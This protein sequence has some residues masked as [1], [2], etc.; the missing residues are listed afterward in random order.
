MPLDSV[1]EKIRVAYVEEEG[2]R[3][4]QEFVNTAIND[5][6]NDKSLKTLSEEQNVSI[7]FY[8]DLKRDSSLL[9]PGAI[10]QIFNLPRSGVGN[11]FGSSQTQSG[12]YLIYRLDSVNAP[13]DT[14]SEEDREQVRSFLAQQLTISE[15]TELQNMTQQALGVEKLN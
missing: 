1:R 3:K 10:N 13:Q 14:M 6:S 5:L 12:D 2:L 15:L 11:V 8:K 4:S 7:E 9:P